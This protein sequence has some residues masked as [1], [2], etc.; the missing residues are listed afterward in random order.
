MSETYTNVGLK[1]QLVK[2]I[3]DQW[4]DINKNEDDVYDT[5]YNHNIHIGGVKSDILYIPFINCP[6]YDFELWSY[7][8]TI[9]NDWT[10]HFEELL[11][12]LNIN[13][14]PA[15]IKLFFVNYYN[16]TDHPL[17]MEKTEELS[18]FTMG[19][20]DADKYKTDSELEDSRKNWKITYLPSFIGPGMHSWVYKGTSEEL[21]KY[22]NENFSCKCPM[23]DGLPFYDQAE[24][25][26]YIV[27][28]ISENEF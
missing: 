23:C 3:H 15:T 28:E 1:V 9:I 14:A 7:D 8:Q 13:Y 11:I 27:R 19:S 17:V 12:N 6:I 5:L 18:S 22:L 2:P 16:G 21:E 24:S 10:D 20:F 25:A 26:E 4:K